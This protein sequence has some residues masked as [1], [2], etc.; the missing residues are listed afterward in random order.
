[1]SLKTLA[2][3]FGGPQG[4]RIFTGHR[5]AYSWTVGGRDRGSEPPAS[6]P[7]TIG[8][9]T[10]LPPPATSRSGGGPGGGAETRPP[11]GWPRPAAALDVHVVQRE[12]PT[13]E[14]KSGFLKPAASLW[15][16][17]ISWPHRVPFVDAC[18]S[19][20]EPPSPLAGL[21]INHLIPC[22]SHT[23]AQ[24]PSF[25]PFSRVCSPHTAT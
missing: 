11:R 23:K 7:R 9:A 14:E 16:L 20:K 5:Q 15:P 25:F 6:A 21:A 1:M 22:G 4:P 3:K 17:R 12:H 13:A 19:S 24:S 8:C 2:L 18:H 10:S